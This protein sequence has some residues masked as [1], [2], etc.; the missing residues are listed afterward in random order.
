MRSTMKK[1]YRLLCVLCLLILLSP[2]ARAEDIV[3]RSFSIIDGRT[4]ENAVPREAKDLLGD[5]KIGRDFDFSASFRTVLDKARARAWDA[6]RGALAGGFRL[7]AAA[8]LCALAACFTE[9]LQREIRIAGTLAV[10]LIALGDVNTLLGLGRE[11]VT[12][13]AAFGKV[14]MPVL[15]AASA[16]SGAVSS[17]GVVYVAVMFVI[18]VLITLLADLKLPLV[19]VDLALVTA[20]GVTGNDGLQQLAKSL[21]NGIT[22]T[23][24]IILGVFVCY[25]MA[26][27][28][29]SGTADAMAVK[30]VKL[31]ISSAIPA[32]GSVVADAAEAVVAGAGIVRGVAGTFGILSILAT[33]LLPFLRL[34]AQYLAFRL[35]AIL[36]ATA[37]AEGLGR[38]LEGI[39][40]AF[41]MILTLTGS[42]AALLLMG[43]FV[44]AAGVRA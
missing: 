29:V 24:R 22:L 30:T 19:W 27:G 5:A 8:A 26:S 15:A 43:V 33:V 28:I 12:Q 31:A 21:K 38:Q 40:S 41:S 34:S 9:R 6:L 25:L 39:G 16:A 42:G 2:A 11:T 14:L 36:A 1:K 44:S 13:I 4:V 32:A 18:D 7:F 17:S 10:T 3:D 20:G 37:G 35:S 23:L